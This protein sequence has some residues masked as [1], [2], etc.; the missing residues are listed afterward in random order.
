M[1]I[2]TNNKKY[3]R[4][5]KNFKKYEVFNMSPNIKIKWK[6]AKDSFIFDDEKKKYIDFT[7][8]IFTSNIG[9][10]N[11][12]FKKNIIKALS[13]GF[14][15]SYTYYND[16]REQYIKKLIEFINSP[17]LKKCFFSL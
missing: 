14:N 3:L 12:Y 7:S 15:H 2:S 1:I 17:K 11:N 9:Y 13:K 16:F 8:G 4:I 5:D 10:G 6:K